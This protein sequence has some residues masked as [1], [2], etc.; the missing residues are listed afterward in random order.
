MDS[1]I[2]I[3][4]V[5]I[6]S[7][8]LGGV[9]GVLGILVN[10]KRPNNRISGW[11]VVVLVGI[12]IS[13]TVGVV[14]SI[15]EN[16]KAKSEAT[17][18]AARTERLLRELSRAIQPITQ[19]EITYWVRFPSESPKVRDYLAK[20]TKG[21]EA[22]IEGLR[23]EF[24]YKPNDGGIHVTA[25]G[26]NDEPLT[27]EI[28]RKSALWPR[29][30]HSDIAGLVGSFSFGVFIRKTPIGE[31]NFEPMI[32]T[33]GRYAD[34]IATAFGGPNR[35][36]LVFDR[37]DGQIEIFGT[38]EYMKSQWNSNG[39]IVSITDLYGAQ[40]FLVLPYYD[41]QLPQRYKKYER[42][43]LAEL[44]RLIDLKTI[45]L[46][47]S[48]GRDMWIDGKAFKKVKSAFGEPMFSIILPADDEGFRRLAPPKE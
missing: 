43:G 1:D 9:L 10:F 29:G 12:V 44:A 16:Y 14:G 25:S 11:G 40:L 39:K 41:F 37:R 30:R 36:H 28:G 19:L 17:Q 27:I 13:A 5:K 7:A 34:W 21:I 31:E 20:V 47:F 45:V 38:T 2:V 4:A 46:K 24:F 26:S 32:S 48:E 22:R 33:G 6:I 35:S 42:H 15:A 18:Q 23:R 3:T 8:L